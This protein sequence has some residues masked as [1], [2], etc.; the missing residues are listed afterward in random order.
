[1]LTEIKKDEADQ[2]VTGRKKNESAN[3]LDGGDRREMTQEGQK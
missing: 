2:E 1:V 3:V